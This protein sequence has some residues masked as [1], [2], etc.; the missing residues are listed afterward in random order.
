MTVEGIPTAEVAVCFADSCNLDLPI[1]RL[2]DALIKGK[3]EMADAHGCLFGR[4][5]GAENASRSLGNA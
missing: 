1:F 3:I 2:V 5:L 4:P